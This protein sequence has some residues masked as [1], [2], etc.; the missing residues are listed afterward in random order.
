MGGLFVGALFIAIPSDRLAS[1]GVGPHNPR[2]VW[3][4]F[5]AD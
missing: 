2:L 5:D 4:T 1:A 3:R